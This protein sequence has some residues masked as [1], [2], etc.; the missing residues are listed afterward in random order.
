MNPKKI[1]AWITGRLGGNAEGLPDLLSSLIGA[2]QI[3]E[4]ERRLVVQ[5]FDRKGADF[6]SC[7]SSDSRLHFRGPWFGGH[8]G[9]Q[10][11]FGRRFL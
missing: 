1:L 11:R 6:F 7:I 4:E 2:D 9:E 10:E 8:H 5:R 3:S